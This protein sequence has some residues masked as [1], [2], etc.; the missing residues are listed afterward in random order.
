[1]NASRPRFGTPYVF[2]V[3]VI[4]RSENPTR[5]LFIANYLP[6][7][8]PAIAEEIRTWKQMSIYEG[9]QK[10]IPIFGY[11]LKFLWTEVLIDV[12]YQFPE[13]INLFER[14]PVGPGALP[15]LKRIN[16]TEEP[17][18][19]ARTLSSL[20]VH[21]GVTFEHKPLRL[22]A[23]NWEGVACEFRKYTNLRAGKGRKRKY[24]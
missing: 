20:D 11:N 4:L 10:I 14:F 23:E 24:S 17:S 9:V 1:M 12:A 22:S 13:Y 19:L 21:T 3:S 18:V 6:H 15:T 7:I 5:E 16:V 8:I 2:P